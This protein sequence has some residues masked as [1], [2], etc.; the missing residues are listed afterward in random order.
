[1]KKVIYGIVSVVLI[2]VIAW[3]IINTHTLN[4]IYE[5]KSGRYTVQFERDGTCTWYQDGTFFSGVYE[6]NDEKWILNI[7]GN[8][9]YWSTVFYAEQQGKDLLVNGGSVNNEVFYKK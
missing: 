8:G 7:S 2:V 5:S 9:F 4:G 6:K 1:M 3:S